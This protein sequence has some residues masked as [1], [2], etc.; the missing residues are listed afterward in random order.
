M[1]TEVDHATTTRRRNITGLIVVIFGI[2]TLL[3][4]LGHEEVV[5]GRAGLL[6]VLTAI[7]EFVHGF[8]RANREQQRSAWVSSAITLA[9]G[10]LLLNTPFLASKALVLFFAGW[11]G[12]DALRYLYQFVRGNHPEYG[13]YYC[14]GAMLGNLLVFGGLLLFRDAAMAW[15]VA[16]AAS[17]R[18]FGIAY[19]IYVMPVFTAVDAGATVL[20][21]Y[22]LHENAELQTIVDQSTKAE[23][24]RISIDR[25]WI[26]AFILTLFAIHLGRMGLDKSAIGVLSP[27]IAVIGDIFMGMLIALLIVIPVQVL[28]LR[29][30]RRLDGK[31]W[32]W[33]LANPDQKRRVGKRIVQT[34]LTYRLKSSIRLRQCRYSLRRTINRGLQ[35]G[36]PLSAIIAAT[37]P[38][39]GM[40]W[41]FDTENWAA[42][43][44]NSWAAART[45]TWREAM[46]LAVLKEEQAQEPSKLFAVQ[47]PGITAGKD[48]SFI[49]IG[50]TGEGDASQHVLR[51]Q[52]LEVARRDDVKFV[53][54]SSDVI[55]P[56]GAMKDYEARFWLPFMGTTKPVYA[57]PGN[58]DWYDALEGFNATFME[59]ASA[60]AAMKARI[61]VDHRITTTTEKHI[62]D[63]INEATRL[64]KEYRVPVQKQKA[65]YFQFQTENFALFAIDTGVVKRL[66]AA[67]M[68]WLKRGLDA[69]KGK[70]KMALLGH[71]LYAGGEY[72]A[73]EKPEF[74]ELHQLL[75]QH[76][77]AVVMGGDTHDLEYYAEPVEGTNSPMHHFV[78]GGG[79]AYLSFGTSLAWPEK[80]PAAEWAYY[81]AKEQV[82][83][84]IEAT[85]PRWKWPA[86]WWTKNMG[87]WPFS[88]EFL[89]AAFDSNV[90]PY[91]QSFMEIRVESA[92]QRLVLIP[93]GIH[94]RLRWADLDRSAGLQKTNA[95]T[96][97]EWVV[98]MK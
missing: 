21:E 39:W 9:M 14:L 24:D 30:T 75:R 54:I 71:P 63:L 48:Y 11:F 83:S 94:G 13:R 35:I 90:A 84:K 57:I 74:Q 65:P 96:L 89:S 33:V 92:K 32:Q 67:Q 22:H 64:G 1:A 55:Y 23:L 93:Y 95:D 80:V 29:S 26:I 76:K 20:E 41:Y 68:I 47:P 77:V 17:L 91:Y 72:M 81:P 38:I 51:S 34:V 36:L 87:G 69:A 88:A 16:I 37:F 45:D 58:H 6:L 27:I 59:P 12:L 98:P 8:R 15:T 4:P 60:R 40:S 82:V 42:G 73:A 43:I 85:T 66:D 2:L 19:N 78:N 70:T 97:V 79:G 25:G 31:I 50:D 10:I 49:V 7:L 3:A 61:E 56:T 46:A 86:W 18:M 44:W 5:G 53:I 28:W 62:D 52:Y